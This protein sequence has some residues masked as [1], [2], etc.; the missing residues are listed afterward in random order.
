MSLNRARFRNCFCQ[1]FWKPLPQIVHDDATRR[2]N[3]IC[4]GFPRERFSLLHGHRKGFEGGGT[5]AKHSVGGQGWRGAGAGAGEAW[6][7]QGEPVCSA[8]LGDRGRSRQRATMSMEDC[9]KREIGGRDPEDVDRL[10]LDQA[11][12]NDGLAHLAPFENLVSLSMN[13][14]SISSLSSMPA[15]NNLATLKLSDNKIKS[16]L[17]SLTKLSALEKLYLGGNQIPD[18]ESL[19]PLKKLSK[20][21]WLDLEGNPVTKVPGYTEK[22]FE[23]LPA[24]M[25]LDGC[26]RDGEELPD[27]DDDDEVCP[28]VRARRAR[29]AR[30]G[31]VRA[32]ARAGFTRT[33]QLPC[34]IPGSRTLRCGIWSLRLPAHPRGCGLCPGARCMVLVASFVS[35][36]S[37]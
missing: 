16:G 26:N 4:T 23:M 20:L 7:R 9:I 12:C 11:K 25:V 14:A 6:G 28:A 27:N 22:V 18:L 33:A 36:P 35:V 32:A 31:G 30:Q 13:D 21:E 1:I 10:C 15:L 3:Q 17:D 8:R 2:R 24:L 34:R 19:D 5:H 29:R 37:F